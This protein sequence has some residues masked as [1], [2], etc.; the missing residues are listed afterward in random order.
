MCLKPICRRPLVNSGQSCIPLMAPRQLPVD[1]RNLTGAT[2][3]TS[4]RTQHSIRT[5]AGDPRRAYFASDPRLSPFL[6]VFRNQLQEA[7]S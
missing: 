6:S 4:S 7:S 2:C 1:R 3:G 5:K